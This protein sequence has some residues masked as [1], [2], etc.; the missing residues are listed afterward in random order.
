[1]SE[2]AEE[3]PVTT[4]ERVPFRQRFPW[5]L[6]AIATFLL[7]SVLLLPVSLPAL[8]FI[9]APWGAADMTAYY[10]LTET[11]DWWRHGFTTLVAFPYGMDSNVYAGLDGLTH[12]VA[13][14][15]S[16][17]FGSVFIGLNLLLL[18]S[19][20]VVA[21]LAYASIRLTGLTGPLAVALAS[22]FTFI[23]FHFG[24]GIGHVHLGMMF[25]L[26]SGVLLALLV[27]SGRLGFWFTGTTSSR[28]IPYG[29]I[30]ALLVIIT[31]WT[32]LYYAFFGLILTLAALLWRIGQGDDWRRML[33][34]LLT[35]TAQV[36][37]MA[38]GLLPVLM[39]R[40]GS[41]AA[42]AVG[43]RDPMDS[44][45]YAGNLA[46]ALVPQPYSVVWPDYNEFIQGMFFEDR[47]LNEAHLMANYGTWITSAAV[48]TMLV[49]LSTYQ[50]RKSLA[51][52][53]PARTTDT[54]P[55]A[56]LTLVGYLSI[57]VAVLFVPWSVNY[58]FAHLVTAQIRAWNR[59]EPYLLLLFI[60]GAAAALA[61][62]KW[63]RRRGV[64][65][66]VSAVIVL[67]TMVEMVLPW[68]NLYMQVPKGGQAKLDSAAAY[69]GEV[70]TAL[71][72]GC[73]ILTL[74]FIEY[75]NAGPTVG[76][77]DYDHFLLPLT[78]PS[79]PVSYGAYRGTQE[80]NQIAELS[81]SITA[82]SIWGLREQ[83]FCAIHLD[84]AGFD[85]PSTPLA[86]LE[87]LFG[88]P[89]AQEGRWALFSVL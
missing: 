82:E 69:A 2:L 34:P 39:S 50:R 62:W 54:P 43:L 36:I 47:P 78:N 45:T 57:V 14:I 77:D 11:W 86:E 75:P 35:V 85:D 27:G 88:P 9:G 48:L 67:V 17:I 19:F 63:P 38:M 70:A 23:P 59:L 42:D 65:W 44:V 6:G 55:R 80:A 1:M 24:R 15:L 21:V 61:S 60:I 87:A 89:V 26:A 58:L 71:P 64:P 56:S 84:S 79:N 13:S 81:S 25:G 68:R 18:L 53:T 51:L 66:V 37:T 83:G 76:M 4:T 73:G 30:L 12:V 49:G 28:R 52:S 22:S 32:G 3:S 20:P 74:P 72:A 10:F 31:S 29:I 33:A 40:A 7:S 16:Q 8:R 41:S 46:I 5:A